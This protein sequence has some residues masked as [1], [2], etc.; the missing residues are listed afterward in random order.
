MNSVED[1][2]NMDGSSCSLLKRE[3]YGE[4]FI[5]KLRSRIG[6]RFCGGDGDGRR[7]YSSE[8][9]R[10]TVRRCAMGMKCCFSQLVRC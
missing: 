1:V 8:L 2:F 5:E 4:R 6:I 3:K 10:K 7:S 9:G